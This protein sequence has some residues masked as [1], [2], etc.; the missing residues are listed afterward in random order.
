MILKIDNY[1]SRIFFTKNVVIIEGDTEDILI[2]E[3]IKKLDRNK[4]FKILSD[5]EIIKA[6][7]KAAII[8]LVKYLI[9]MGI[10]PIVVHDIDAE[11]PNAAKYNEPIA[12]ALNGMGKIVLMSNNVEDE[13]GYIATY[14]KPFKAYNQTL[15]WGENWDDLPENWRKK[16]SE[17]FEEYL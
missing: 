15:T 14:E 9:S 6:R 2:K 12:A 7:G 3:S 13:L 1:V 8:G 5:F 11:E 4:Y 10:N 16:M 17:I